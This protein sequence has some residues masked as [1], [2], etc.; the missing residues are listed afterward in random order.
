MKEDFERTI[1]EL[2]SYNL[3]KSDTV[4]KLLFLCSVSSSVKVGDKVRI[5][6]YNEP[7]VEVLEINKDKALCRL[8]NGLDNWYELYRIVRL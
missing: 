5:D 8:N 6:G 7:N 3:T 1:D 2:I 4:N